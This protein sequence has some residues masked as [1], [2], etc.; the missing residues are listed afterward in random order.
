MD[1]FDICVSYVNGD[2][3]RYSIVSYECESQH[4]W[5]IPSMEEWNIFLKSI[6]NPDC[7]TGICKDNIKSGVGIKMNIP[8]DECEKMK[9]IND[10]ICFQFKG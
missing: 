3:G 5:N 4:M 8:N 7:G 1:E 9:D 10:L 2:K 6:Y